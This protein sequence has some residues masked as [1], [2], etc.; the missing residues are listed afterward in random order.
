M[1]TTTKK[2][3]KATVRASAPNGI[4]PRKATP[5][6]FG[7]E[8]FRFRLYRDQRKLGGLDIDP[9]VEQADWQRSGAKREGNLTFRRPLDERS[10]GL[11]VA[12]DT[13]LCEVALTGP[14]GGWRPLWRMAISN[15]NDEVFTGA[16]GLTLAS[17]M[18]ASFTGSKVAWK[19]VQDRAHPHGWTAKQITVAVAKR[20]GIPL[21]SLPS[22]GHRIVRL[23]ERSLSPQ[24]IVTRAWQREREATGRRF[25]LDTSTG[26][27][28]VRELREPAYMLLIGDA[29]ATATLEQSI[30]QIA[31][32]IIATATRQASGQPGHAGYRRQ[33]LMR[34]EVKSPGRQ[35]SYGD[36]LKTLTAPAGID[37]VAELRK[38]AKGQLTTIHRPKS[39]VTFT[40]PGLPL[41]DRSDAMRLQLSEVGFDQV[42]FVT[43]CQHAVSAGSYVMTVS[44]GFDDPWS[45]DQQAA[46]AAAKKTAAAIKRGRTTISKTT[47]PAPKKAST[48]GKYVPGPKPTASQLALSQLTT[49]VTP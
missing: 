35:T 29:I 48:R 4:W 3:A 27:L 9:W 45:A 34:V 14:A 42:V 13:V 43:D 26:F 36:V 12:G 32:V 18:S 23:V 22:A 49:S 10:A 38:W 17:Q 21:G 5:L 33:K 37:T 2:P 44:V 28:S 40:H 6:E 46:D 1:A 15:P 16:I 30:E 39:T 19:F 7:R 47:P 31:T 11:I 20:F 8:E 24:D 25:D 41:L